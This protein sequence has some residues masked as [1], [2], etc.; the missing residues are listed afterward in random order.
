[1]Q[2]DARHP[3]ARLPEPVHHRLRAGRQPHLEH[4]AATSSSRARTIACVV[5]HALEAGADEVEVTEA[6]EQAWV[7]DAGEQPARRSAAT[8]TARPATTTTRAARSTA[9]CALSTSGYPMGP[10]AFFEFIDGWRDSGD[11]RRARVPRPAPDQHVAGTTARARTTAPGARGRA[12]SACRPPGCARPPGECDRR[13]PAHRGERGVEP[14]AVAPVR[15]HRVGVAGRRTPVPVAVVAGRGLGQVGREQLDRA[16][17]RVVGRSRIP[18]CG[19]RGMERAG[20]R[21]ELLPSDHLAELGVHRPQRR[22]RSTAGVTGIA[23]GTSRTTDGRR[24]PPAAPSRASRRRATA[25]AARSAGQHR[26]GVIRLA[27]GHERRDER[28]DD[29]DQEEPV[30]PPRA[31]RREPPDARHREASRPRRA[32]TAAPGSTSGVWP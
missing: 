20:L 14:V 6:A 27:A 28:D 5:A 23:S 21:R 17:L 31:V 18:A 26:G 11:V 7:D 1:M 24:A 22:R 9:G 2:L 16:G 13:D 8:P 29:G 25:P 3:R 12:R 32:G 10:V 15:D 30:R 4:H 19:Y